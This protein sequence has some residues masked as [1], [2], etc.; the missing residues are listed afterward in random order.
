MQVLLMVY[1]YSTQ[2]LLILFLLYLI[3]GIFMAA[4][5]FK[6]ISLW[7]LMGVYIIGTFFLGYRI[8]TH[9][10][11]HPILLSLIDSVC[12]FCNYYGPYN[13]FFG[14][15]TPSDLPYGLDVDFDS[16]D[17]PRYHKR[18]FFIIFRMFILFGFVI[19]ANLIL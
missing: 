1:S 7:I 6:S 13:E 18:L 14:Y 15:I 12:M 10:P 16:N 3:C 8:F 4:D 11:I 9:I 17:M 2:I 5:T 19:L